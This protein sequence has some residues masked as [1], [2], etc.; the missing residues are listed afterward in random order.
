M[1]GLRGGDSVAILRLGYQRN[2]VDVDSAVAQ[3]KANKVPIKAVVM[4]ATYQA[5]PKF[6]EKTT[7]RIL[8]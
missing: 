4:V 1:R 6:I 7:M 3:L 2:T 8:A 5:A